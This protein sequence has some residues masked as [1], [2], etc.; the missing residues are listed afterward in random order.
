MQLVRDSISVYIG[1]TM[2][3]KANAPPRNE[4]SELNEQLP[5][6]AN[7]LTDIERQF[8]KLIQVSYNTREISSNSHVTC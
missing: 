2:E 8:W 1:V 3:G 7:R 6:T 5:M 4:D